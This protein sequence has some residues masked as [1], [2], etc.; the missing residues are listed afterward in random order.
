MTASQL[1]LLI[2]LFPALGAILLAA[3]RVKARLAGVSDNRWRRKKPARKQQA[4]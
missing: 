4:E 2:L 1:A 3:L